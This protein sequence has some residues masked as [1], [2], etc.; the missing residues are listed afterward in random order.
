MSKRWLVLVIALVALVALVAVGCGQSDA[1][2]TTQATT[3]D[4]GAAPAASG[5]TVTIKY[6]DQNP[7]TGWEGMEAAK[8]WLAQIEEATNGRAKVQAYWSETLWKGTDAWESIKAGV[9][10]MGWAFHGYWAGMTSLSDVVTLPFMPIETG[11]EGSE[12]LWQLYEEFPSIQEQYKDNHIVTLWTSSPYY[13]MTVNKEVKT[14]ADLKGLKI[15]TT[16]GPPTDV[17]KAMGAVPVSMGMPDT[18]QALQ[19]G[20][21]DGILQQWEAA[22]S[23]RHYEVCKYQTMVPVHLVYFSQAFNKARWD[24]V[25]ADIQ[26]QIMSVGGMEGAKF[27]GANMFDSAA[28]EIENKLKTE[29]YQ[30][31]HVEVAPEEAASWREQFGKPLWEK[32]VQK[33]EAEGHPEARDILNRCI[34]LAEKA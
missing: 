3:A 4:G 1:P 26:E 15:R 30:V 6:G 23:F 31:A 34:E 9:G 8:P 19:T 2:E 18:Y 10:D 28:A 11:A 24:K 7:E 17:M 16:G 14:L 32:W 13:I 12:I 20:V 25:P 27:W 29:G 5:E 33:M 22:Y 21:L